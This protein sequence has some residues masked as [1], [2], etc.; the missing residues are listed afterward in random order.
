MRIYKVLLQEKKN[1][2]HLRF[3]VCNS[4]R[5]LGILINNLNEDDFDIIKIEGESKIE[6]D[7]MEFVKKTPGLEQGNK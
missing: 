5:E 1:D 6:E 4:L 2:Q 7:Y 3:P